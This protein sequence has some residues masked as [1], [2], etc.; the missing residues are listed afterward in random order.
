VAAL[1]HVLLADRLEA[2][3][4]IV[5]LVPARPLLDDVGALRQGVLEHEEPRE[6]D[7]ARED[8]RGLVGW[9]EGPP[10][11]C[12]AAEV[13]AE[14]ASE[15]E[16]EVAARRRPAHDPPPDQVHVELHQRL[17][18]LELAC[19]AAPAQAVPPSAAAV[20]IVVVV[21]AA[22]P[23][24]ALVVEGRG[25]A[26]DVVEQLALGVREVV[27]DVEEPLLQLD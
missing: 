1:D 27:Q 10:R 15:V 22:P 16:E 7:E 6:P 9:H 4:G 23:P 19:D 21:V 8:A 25:H 3:E 26:P 12:A 17:L 13:E 14:Y 5:V 20:V 18:Q 24:L 11:R 2:L